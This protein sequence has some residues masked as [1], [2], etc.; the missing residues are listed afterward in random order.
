MELNS[1][2]QNIKQAN[3]KFDLKVLIPHLKIHA[4]NNRSSREVIL[5]LEEA[6][7]K[8]KQIQDKESLKV[9]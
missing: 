5:L 4:S 8:S 6:I 1:I 9:H 2:K 3:S 7:L